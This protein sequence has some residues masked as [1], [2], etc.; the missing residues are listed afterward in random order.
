MNIPHKQLSVDINRK[1][2]YTIDFIS[3]VN[4]KD[5]RYI[6]VTF[7]AGGTPI[8]LEEG[9]TATVTYV[10]EGV[11]IDQA[12]ECT[13]S[14]STVVIGVDS[15]KVE[16]LRSGIL[17]VQPKVVDP[18]G[19]ILTM[20]IPILVRI[21]PDIA[22]H[23][24]VDDDSLGSY[25]EVVR[26]IAAARGDYPDLKDRLDHTGAP[27]DEQVATAVSEW[28]DDHP[29]ATTTVED[30]AVTAAK[31]GSGAVTAAKLGS[32]VNTILDGKVIK[33]STSPNGTNGQ[34]LRTKGDGTT[35][36][37]DVG[38]P[39][40]AQTAEAVSDWLDDHPEATTT[41]ED[42]SITTA[43]LH[44][45]VIDST[46]STQGAAAEA[47]KTGDVKNAAEINRNNISEIVEIQNSFN[48]YSSLD[49]IGLRTA[50][51]AEVSSDTL[52]STGFI[53]LGTGY[54]HVVLN[55][56][57]FKA[58]F[59]TASQ[60]HIS[61]NEANSTAYAI[62]DTAVYCRFSFKKASV[63]FNVSDLKIT[64]KVGS[65]QPTTTKPFILR[66]E[67]IKIPAVEAQSIVN[68]NNSLYVID[69]K[70]RLYVRG[71]QGWANNP[72][73]LG[74]QAVI[75]SV[76]NI[77]LTISAGYLLSCTFFS[78]A[79]ASVENET[80]RHSGWV[81]ETVIEK[82]Q[83]FIINIKKADESAIS[84][85]E[86]DNLNISYD[87]TELYNHMSALENLENNSSLLTWEIGSIYQSTGT[88]YDEN[89]Y[90]IRTPSSKKIHL[91]AN[92]V[93]KSTN[94]D[95]ISVFA[96]EYD[97]AGTFVARHGTTGNKT[98]TLPNEG[99]YRVAV[100]KAYNGTEI[101]ENTISLYS[102]DTAILG[103]TLNELLQPFTTYSRGVKGEKIDLKRQTY[104]IQQMPYNLPSSGVEGIISRQDFAIYNGVLFQL[105]DSDYVVLINLSDGTRIAGYEISCAHGN[106]CQFSNEFYSE[107]DTYPLLYCFGYGDN[108]VYVNRVTDSGAT[109][110]RTYKLDTEGYRFS[111]GIDCINNRLVTIH[112]HLNYSSIATDNYNIVTVWD[113]NKTTQNGDGTLTP[114][115]IKQTAIDFIPTI[116]GCKWFKDRLFINNGYYPE[117]RNFPVNIKAMT[118][119]GT[120]TTLIDDLPVSVSQSEG[121]GIDFYYQNGKYTMYI[122][123]YSLYRVVFSE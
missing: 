110:V 120:I 10:S 69:F 79:V 114:E 6:D 37:V 117:G 33:P 64:A 31:L 76:N 40:D 122:S 16:N 83:Y 123:T 46:L 52:W 118:T 30:G 25:A 103:Q 48:S 58:C 45:G 14:G 67:N 42:G 43:K 91:A 12:A 22:E 102:A 116:Q 115:I 13:V 100:L 82:G 86:A 113:L 47:K 1:N 77:K 54:T 72:T 75:K 41:V 55:Y 121:E 99:Y 73:R 68:D 5:V 36:W 94:P 18:N 101:T 4:D 29:E 108:K 57:A 62:P 74:S 111:G 17:E 2:Q 23:G 104:E 81:S 88:N 35:E 53:Y 106:S 59:Y 19:R 21:S 96:F 26:E 80:G 44:S 11:L 3:H 70:N 65:S 95:I 9:C 15:E 38:L 61:T 39:T 92:T 63:S 90:A 78:S 60:T 105:Y 32:D 98:V 84:P 109:L 119:D 56:T 27:T 93:V 51:G 66:E 85:S 107:N 71:G 8:T 7:N 112:Y 49:L 87:D 28:L 97:A 89:H 50:T 24:Q 34:L 20:Q